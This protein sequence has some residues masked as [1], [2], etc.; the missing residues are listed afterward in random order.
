MPLTNFSGPLVVEESP[1]AKWVLV[2]PLEYRGKRQKF[3]IPAGFETDFASVP[4]VLWSV[5]PPYGKWLKAAVLHDMLY[6]TPP[7]G[8]TRR[9][10]DGLFRRVLKEEGCSTWRACVMYWALRAFG[11]VAWRSA[12]K[13]ER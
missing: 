7:R 9:D 6:A 12:R 4:R 10:A 2:H 3:R 8:V 1:G 13:A 11:W 5:F